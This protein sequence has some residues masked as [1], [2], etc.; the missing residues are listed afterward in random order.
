MFSHYQH[1]SDSDENVLGG[2]KKKTLT[3]NKNACGNN[4]TYNQ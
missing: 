1:S 4:T 2:H 3:T